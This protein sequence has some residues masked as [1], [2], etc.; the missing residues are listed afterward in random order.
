MTIRRLAIAV[1]V[2]GALMTGAQA[3]ARADPPGAVQCKNGPGVQTCR[4]PDGSVQVC[5][6]GG[7]R[8]VASPPPPGF[9]D[10]P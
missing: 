7:C 3:V 1:S 5:I 4:F 10:Q 2:V 9:W 6:Y 8:P